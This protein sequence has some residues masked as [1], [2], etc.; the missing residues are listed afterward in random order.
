MTEARIRVSDSDEVQPRSWVDGG[1]LGRCEV[2]QVHFNKQLL[3][4]VDESVGYFSFF[5]FFSSG[6]GVIL[7]HESVGLVEEPSER[8]CS[9]DRVSAMVTASIIYPCAG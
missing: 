1:P 4:F 9:P 5:S 8:G 2:R 3:Q 7:F 6:C